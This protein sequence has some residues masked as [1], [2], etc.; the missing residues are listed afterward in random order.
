MLSHIGEKL[1]IPRKDAIVF[2]LFKAANFEP[3]GKTIKEVE[4]FMTAAYAFVEENSWFF[5][6]YA[7]GRKDS[8]IMG[9]PKFIY[10]PTTYHILKELNN[11]K[12][13]GETEKEIQNKI[14][15]YMRKY[16]CGSERNDELDNRVVKIKEAYI[17]LIY[18]LPY[19][20]PVA[21]EYVPPEYQPFFEY[22]LSNYSNTYGSIID[23][24]RL[25]MQ[26]IRQVINVS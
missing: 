16:Y 15:E 21:A 20:K 10:G 26:A 1:E 19:A 23:S 5:L 13:S 4:Y 12:N 17:K 9:T 7:Y 8:V 14:D 22:A 18:Q 11:M 3:T 6:E 24:F 25:Y 2:G